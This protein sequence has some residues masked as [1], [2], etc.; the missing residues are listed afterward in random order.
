L[1]LILVEIFTGR[2]L[3]GGF[4]VDGSPKGNKKKEIT[5]AQ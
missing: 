1:L 3:E 4:W 5:L 2:N